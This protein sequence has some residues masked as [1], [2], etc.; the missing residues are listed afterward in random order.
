VRGI[1]RDLA[2]AGLGSLKPLGIPQ[3][4]GTFPCPVA[5]RIEDGDGCPAF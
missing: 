4:Q 2:A 3:I 1:A 5:V